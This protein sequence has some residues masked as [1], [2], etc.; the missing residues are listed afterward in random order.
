[1]HGTLE[2][3]PVERRRLNGSGKANGHAAPMDADA[4]AGAITASWQKAVESIIQTGRLLIESKAALR[5]GEW[6]R[7]VC[8]RLPFGERTAQVL[9][10]IAEHPVLSNPNHAAVLPACWTTLAELAQLPPPDLEALI[11]DRRIRSDMQRKD[12]AALRHGANW[13]A[14]AKAPAWRW[15]TDPPVRKRWFA[16]LG[17]DD[18]GMPEPTDELK[19]DVAAAERLMEANRILMELEREYADPERLVRLLA[20]A[21]YG[22]GADQQ[23][24]WVQWFETLR[25][26]MA[27]AWAE[28]EPEDVEARQ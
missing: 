24:S 23:P 20:T 7:M 4:W 15:W 13:N 11:A 19:R 6:G 12:A 5:H 22:K 28:P 18:P 8:R 1:M 3:A 26:G 16:R 9:M 10:A 17:I 27:A 21:G 25:L 14:K 2:R